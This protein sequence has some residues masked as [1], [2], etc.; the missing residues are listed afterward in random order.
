MEV[1]CGE[2]GDV[3][4]RLVVAAKNNQCARFQSVLAAGSAAAAA[5]AAAAKVINVDKVAAIDKLAES[6]SAA[7]ADTAY[8]FVDTNL[9]HSDFE[10]PEVKNKQTA[11]ND[12]WP[13]VKVANSLSLALEGVKETAI[14]DDI[15]DDPM[16]VEPVDDYRTKTCDVGK[17]E[18]ARRRLL[19]NKKQVFLTMLL[20]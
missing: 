1:A 2:Y 9:Y 5:A 19:V 8:V 7:T 13:V 15:E 16:D 11:N 6:P 17:P 3:L 20:T 4:P 18:P 10:L 12:L 14:L